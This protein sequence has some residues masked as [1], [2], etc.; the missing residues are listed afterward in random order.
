MNPL[1]PNTPIVNADGIVTEAFRTLL[2]QLTNNFLLTGQGAPEGVL[3]ASKGVRYMDEDGV[4]GSVLYIKQ[5]DN[6]GGDRSLGWI[7]V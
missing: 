1:N 6:I 4:T 5:K 7:L 3:V 2:L